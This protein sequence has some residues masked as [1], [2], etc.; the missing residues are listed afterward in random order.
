MYRR[1][2]CAR[3]NEP[4]VNEG[5]PRAAARVSSDSGGSR[6]D[7]FPAWQ[8]NVLLVVALGDEELRSKFGE[9]R[10]TRREKRRHQTNIAA[11]LSQ[12]LI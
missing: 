11:R 9:K 5:S 7:E 3:A 1:R 12:S 10:E 2:G 4:Y 8:P 6:A